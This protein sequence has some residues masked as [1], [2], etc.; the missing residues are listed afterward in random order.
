MYRIAQEATTNAARH[1]RAT[2]VTIELRT[3][4][5]R[6][7]LSIVDN[8][9]GLRNG[10]SK[11]QPGMGLKIMEYRARTIGGSIAF[12][13]LQKGTR[14]GLS[15]SLQLLRK[16]RGSVHQKNKTQ[17]HIIESVPA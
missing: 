8:G 9:I 11:G 16:P 14:I 10:L 15:C 6:L 1:A 2:S 4:A 3:T 5:R 13:T 7:H 17:R 12:E